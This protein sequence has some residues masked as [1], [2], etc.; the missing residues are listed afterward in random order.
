M[1]N[2]S[3]QPETEVL[4]PWQQW[5][6]PYYVVNTCVALSWCLLRFVVPGAELLQEPGSW[7]ATKERE[8]FMLVGF[9][10]LAKARRATSTHEYLFRIFLYAKI[11]LGLLLVRSENFVALAFF[12]CLLSFLFVVLP[13]PTFAGADKVQDMTAIA[14]T[15]TVLKKTDNKD[16][17]LY[18]VIFAADWCETCAHVS[19][20]FCG[21]AQDFTSRR[22]VFVKMDIGIFPN[23]GRRFKVDASFATRQLPTFILFYQGHEYR[24]LPYFDNNHKVVKTKFTKDSLHAFLLLDKTPKDAIAYLKKTN[25]TNSPTTTLKQQETTTTQ[26]KATTSETHNKRT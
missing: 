6:Q 18:L 21:L 3:S 7:F 14:F 1:A 20:L 10:L 25:S 2:A 16:D 19:P 9:G 17:P 11:A 13:T 24:R 15:E 23:V 5:T 12:G 4:K 26:D 8:V 22:R